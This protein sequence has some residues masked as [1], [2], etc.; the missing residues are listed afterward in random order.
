MLKKNC[1]YSVYLVLDPVLTEKMG[2]VKT[3]ELAIEGGATIVQLRAPQWKKRRRYECALALKDVLHAYHVPL[4][5]DDDLDIAL[6]CNADGVHVG[7]KDLPVHIVRKFLGPDKIVGLSI[8]NE[9][10]MLAVD[11]NVV[12]YVGVGP[13]FSTTTKPDAEATIGIDGLAKLMKSCPV[14]AVAIGGIKNHHIAEIATTGVQGIAVVSA[15]CG[16]NDP[17]G[18]ARELSELWKHFHRIITK[19]APCFNKGRNSCNDLGR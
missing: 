18:S 16:Q 7:Q 19:E 5:I 1:N 14:P 12:D 13:V 2:M 3:A 15:I 9:Q 10:Q 17:L 11:P 6:A 8:N 4:I